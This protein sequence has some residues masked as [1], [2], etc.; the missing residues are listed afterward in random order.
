MSVNW[1][2]GGGHWV[3]SI[4]TSGSILK[5][6]LTVAGGNFPIIVVMIPQ[7]SVIGAGGSLIKN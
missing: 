1:S 3:E 2:L 4:L 5:L 6:F 7:E